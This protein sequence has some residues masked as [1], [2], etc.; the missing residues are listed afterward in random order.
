MFV[1]KNWEKM[2][3][4]VR[5]NGR[6]RQVLPNVGRLRRELAGLLHHRPRPGERSGKGLVEGDDGF[7]N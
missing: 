6:L 4:Y 7:V 3:I 5:I 2:K 1:C